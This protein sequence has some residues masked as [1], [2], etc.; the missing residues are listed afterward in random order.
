MKKIALLA[1]L[2]LLVSG[3]S[4]VQHE[5]ADEKP[6]VKGALH[7]SLVRDYADLGSLERDSTAI[8]KASP[9]TSRIIDLNGIPATVTTMSITRVISGAVPS[10][11]I[12]VLQIGQQ[13]MSLE[14]TSKIVRRDRDYLMFVKPYHLTPGDSTGLYIITGERG[15]YEYDKVSARYRFAGGHSDHLPESLGKEQIDSPEFLKR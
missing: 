13:G 7:A 15:I 8:V 9:T 2:A 3:C 6:A 5:V 14:D 10:D 12:P 11:S 4:S 1:G